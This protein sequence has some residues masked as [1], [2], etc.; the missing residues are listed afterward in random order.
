M[1]LTNVINYIKEDIIMPRRDGTGPNGE[2]QKTGKG[3]GN[4]IDENT[5]C[6]GTRKRCC[7]NVNREFY[8]NRMRR[9]NQ[10]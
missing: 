7:K 6:N 8:E 4:C 5:C 10:N 1:L 2:G 9:N 3:Q